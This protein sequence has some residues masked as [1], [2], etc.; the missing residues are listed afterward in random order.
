VVI[1]ILMV[2]PKAVRTNANLAHVNGTIVFTHGTYQ[3]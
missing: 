1:K 2:G 3:G